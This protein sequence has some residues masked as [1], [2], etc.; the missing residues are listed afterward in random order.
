MVSSQP[1][2][3][4][5]LLFYFGHPA[6]YHF[7]KLTVN[8]LRETGHDIKILIKSK[9]ILEDILKE[10]KEEYFNILPEGRDESKMGIFLGLLRR[11]FRLLMYVYNKK[12]DLMIGTDPS[13]SHIGWLLRIPV[14]TVL[15]DDIDVVPA[16][17]RLTFPFTNHIV[18]PEVVR[19]GRFIKKKIG[20]NGYM[21][22][23]YLHP[24]Y[25]SSGVPV[26]SK[27]Y[28]LIRLSG[29]NAYHDRGI[30]GLN[31]QLLDRIIAK[32]S[33]KG[34]VFISSEKKLNT[35]YARYIL[36]IEYNDLHRFLSNAEMLISDSQSMSMEAAMLGIPS[37][38]FSDFAGRISVL[39]ELERKYH[40]TFGI[41][42]SKP[43]QLIEKIDELL[44]INDH[45]A[46]FKKRREDMLSEKIDVTGFMIWFIENYPESVKI[47]KNNP[48]YQGRF[49]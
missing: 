22:L 11:D 43:Q 32:I 4:K 14:I 25:F 13:L 31:E 47:M 49:N 37:I 12:I 40:L 41:P 29:L 27:P 9:D 2:K 28:F 19:V 23:A 10:S 44:N 34:D 15:E 8:R 18:V 20:Y 35:K 7:L 38:R 26:T 21:K 30:N 33:E 45:K 48:E 39:E 24:K 6:Q 3:Q 16:L 42:A 36:K 5:K 46:I 17:A 1:S